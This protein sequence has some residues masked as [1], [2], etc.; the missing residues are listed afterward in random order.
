M[1]TRTNNTSAYSF[2]DIIQLDLGGKQ[3]RA[4]NNNII[5]RFTRSIQQNTLRR[6]STLRYRGVVDW[7]Y[8]SP[9]GAFIAKCLKP[10]SL[11][12]DKCARNSQFEFVIKEQQGHIHK[13]RC[14]FMRENTP[15][16]FTSIFD[17]RP[18]LHEEFSGGLG[19]YLRLVVKK[20]DLLF[21]DRG[22]FFRL[23]RW[24]LP[25]PRWLS[26]GRFE[27]LHRNIAERRFQV[28]I[29]IAHPLLGTLFYQRGDFF[30]TRCLNE[31]NA[32]PISSRD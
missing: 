6:Q 2:I 17:H 1:D 13:Q 15:F 9:V 4:L 22:Y 27:L 20:G 12:P 28:I 32:I 18:H 21:R 14:Y 26:V 24:R 29:R 31:L 5:R 3:W 7:V 16:T 30:D 19:M 8:C 25:I 11:L 23:W 10:F